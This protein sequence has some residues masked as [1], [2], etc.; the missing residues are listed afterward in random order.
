MAGSITVTTTQ[1]GALTQYSVA[2][3][4]DSSGN[5]SASSFAVKS[6]ELMQVM[7][8]PDGGD[9]QPSN[10]YDMAIADAN[11][12]DVLAG[13]GADLSNSTATAAVPTIST[14][15]RRQV[16]AGNL[17]PNIS[18]AGSAKGGTVALLIR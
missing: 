10:A 1:V 16:V 4:S 17:T 15:F 12:A 8:T 3:V 14:Y 11:G 7:F 18:N 6:G 13:A 9:T 2:W 5:V